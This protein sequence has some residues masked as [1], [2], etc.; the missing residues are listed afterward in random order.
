MIKTYK[1][2]FYLKQRFTVNNNKQDNFKRKMTPWQSL[3]LDFG[4]LKAHSKVY[5]ETM[6]DMEWNGER[7]E[8][9]ERSQ[10]QRAS[11][12]P[13]ER[14]VVCPAF[15]IYTVYIYIYNIVMY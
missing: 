9:G 13:A 4:K 11:G 2:I 5:R 8:H 14:N 10:K 12:E 3:S 7:G 1:F 6:A 15:I